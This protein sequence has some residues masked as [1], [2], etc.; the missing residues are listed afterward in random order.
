MYFANLLCQ[1]SLF[2]ENSTSSHWREKINFLSYPFTKQISPQY[3]HLLLIF[4]RKNIGKVFI[5]LYS[6]E[7]PTTFYHS[8]KS[9]LK[10]WWGDKAIYRLWKWINL[11]LKL[12]NA[13]KIIRP[14]WWNL[15]R[16][17]LKYFWKFSFRQNFH[18]YLQTL[19]CF[20]STA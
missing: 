5:R 12:M 11:S 6:F 14:L 3:C 17:G 8:M 4:W 1:F 13:E 2:G 15:L 9:T 19:L 18:Q 10:P 16:E 7:I 20:A